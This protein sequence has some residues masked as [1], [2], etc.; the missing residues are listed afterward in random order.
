M[1]ISVL[2][3]TYRQRQQINYTIDGRFFPDDLFYRY[4]LPGKTVLIC[5]KM[6][7][8]RFA[9]DNGFA[10]EAKYKPEDFKSYIPALAACIKTKAEKGY[11][12]DEEE[13]KGDFLVFK[14]SDKE[15][16]RE[17]SQNAR[18]VASKILVS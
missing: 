1:P 12:L 10:D 7:Y 5:S 16:I 17:A 11:V 6:D 2:F 4:I 3:Q 15:R 14:R 18:N 9:R 13:S 8:F